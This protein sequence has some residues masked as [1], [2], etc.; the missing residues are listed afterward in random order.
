[1]NGNCVGLDPEK[2]ILGW[3]GAWLIR[4]SFIEFSTPRVGGVGT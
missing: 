3:P 1:M 4:L 2:S